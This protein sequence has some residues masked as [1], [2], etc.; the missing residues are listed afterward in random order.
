MDNVRQHEIEL[1]RYALDTLTA[2]HGDDLLIY[3]PHDVDN[4]GAVLSFK[5]RDLHPHD[6]SQILDERNI[7]VRAGH[8]C[9]KPLMKLLSAHATARASFYLHTT[10]DEIDALSEA[11]AG[12][13]DIFGF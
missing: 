3:G 6:I 12:A 2:R 11:L 8:H 1:T 7:C 13:G 9:A 10:T 4:R 5:F